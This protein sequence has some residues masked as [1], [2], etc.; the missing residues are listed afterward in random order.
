[1][2]KAFKVVKHEVIALE[3]ISVESDSG[4]REPDA[5]EIERLFQ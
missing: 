3:D 1:M 5:E 2:A 4:G